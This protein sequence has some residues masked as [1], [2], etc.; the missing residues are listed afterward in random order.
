MKNTEDTLAGSFPPT[1]WTQILIVI[2]GD[3]EE[4]AR[5]ALAEFYERYRVAIIKFFVRRGC[6]YQTAEDYTHAFFQRKLLE[7]WSGKQTFLHQ[8]R[9]KEDR[10]FRSFLSWML[11]NYFKDELKAART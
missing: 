5:M 10:K 1:M 7:Q 2:Q 6:A 3:N 11:W 8:A 4:A 9:R